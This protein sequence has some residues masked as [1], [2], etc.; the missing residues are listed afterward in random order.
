MSRFLSF[1][2]VLCLLF[3]CTNDNEED[4]F[5]CDLETITYNSAIQGIIELKCISC[6]ATG[7]MN[8]PILENYEDVIK[9]IGDISFLIISEEDPMPPST[10]PQLT[11]CE[12]LQI[13]NWIDNGLVE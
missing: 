10:A 13:Q 8:G 12:K 4:F 9:V 1:F 7:N 3:G 6:H 11:D 5:S 2:I